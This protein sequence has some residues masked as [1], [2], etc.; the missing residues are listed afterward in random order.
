MEAS[1]KERSP[2]TVSCSHQYQ[3]LPNSKFPRKSFH[4][5]G[6]AAVSY[7]PPV[8][9]D[10][11]SSRLCVP[12]CHVRPSTVAEATSRSWKATPSHHRNHTAPDHTHS[13]SYTS[14]GKTNFTTSIKGHSKSRYTC[15]PPTKRA[16]ISG[17]DVL[18]AS[19]ASGV[20][21][22]PRGVAKGRVAMSEELSEADLLHLTLSQ[23]CGMEDSQVEAGTVEK[24]SSFGEPTRNQK[25]T[26]DSGYAS[27][28]ISALKS[29][30][31]VG[32]DTKCLAEVSDDVTDLLFAEVAMEE[33]EDTLDVD[34][35]DMDTECCSVSEDVVQHSDMDGWDTVCCSV[36]KNVDKHS[37]I[38]SHTTSAKDNIDTTRMLDNLKDQ[39]SSVNERCSVSTKVLCD[40]RSNMDAAVEH[41]HVSTDVLTSTEDRHGHVTAIRPQL[42]SLLQLRLQRKSSRIPATDVLAPPMRRSPAELSML[43]VPHCVQAVSSCNAERFRFPSDYFSSSVQQS[44]C[45]SVCVGDGCVV[46]LQNGSAG[47][48]ELWQAFKSSPGV[49]PKLI[50][51]RWF[52]NH[53]QHLVTK[54]ASMEVMYPDTFALQCLTPNWLMLQVKYRYDREIDRAERSAIHKICEHDDIPSRRIVLYV[55][56]CC[57]PTNTEG[58]LSRN[59]NTDETVFGDETPAI[60]DEGQRYRSPPPLLLELSDGWYGLPCVL[61]A[62]LQHMVTT[63]RIEVGTK[64]VLCGMEVLGLEAPA[65][66]LEVPATCRL[67][68]SA[69][70]SRRARWYAKLGFQ[71]NP[72]PF[73][74]GLEALFADGGKVGCVDAVI[75]RVYPVTYLEKGEEGAAKRRMRCVR[76]E[77]RECARHR[78]QREKVVERISLQ[79]QRDYENELA[80]QGQLIVYGS[81]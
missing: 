33:L 43:G 52:A 22:R 9:S 18:L 35:V 3:T 57:S 61:D 31:P 13:R 79:I 28:E 36:S 62:P 2:A 44:V 48:S 73:P 53:F 78:K 71:P 59:K 42:G 1:S 15:P 60:Q 46:T 41:C 76:S 72:R 24:N 34:D 63:G 8:Y 19:R 25:V 17:H 51:Y 40:H 56:K 49:D 27:R 50:S 64:L 77:E 26:E 4:V 81:E 12:F 47:I 67:S 30:S 80:K 37:D 66:P 5:F 54:L 75:A 23:V 7:T 45:G 16:P 69:N 65:H 32:M 70:S 29:P 38:G 58:V 11:T 55:S 6:N 14:T 68:I 74:T 20:E 21:G 10:N 39:H